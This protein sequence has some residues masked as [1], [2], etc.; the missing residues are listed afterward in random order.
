ML[1]LLDTHQHL[2][3]RDKLTY[4]WADNVPVLST[5]DFTI[6]DYHAL[7]AGRG[8]AGSIFME[9]D[10]GDYCAETRMVAELVADP[11]NR[12]LAIISSCR[13]EEDEGFDDWIEE[14]GSLPVVGFRRLL[15]E[16]DD[17]VSQGET[18]RRNVAR[19]GRRGFTFDIVCRSDQLP[20]AH[21]F[22]VSCDDMTL[23][24]DHCG[25]PDIAGG[26]TESWFFGIK[27]MAALPHVCAKISG[28][29][30]YCA[31]DNATLEAVRPYVEHVIASFGTERLVWGSDWPVVNMGADLRQWIDV[32][33]ALIGDLSESEA[34]GIA[35]KNAERIYGVTL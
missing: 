29:L 19:I 1:P 31:P 8:V 11:E 15:H 32:F 4:A 33:R 12:L 22:A 17:S 27:N 5:G 10:A 14:C 18:F 20:I 28:V 30:A 23:V 21:E 24:L 13:P 35:H 6:D 26:E 2:I 16:V 25:V 7:V 34:A 3:Y 9:A